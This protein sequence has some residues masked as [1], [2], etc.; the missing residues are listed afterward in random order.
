MKKHIFWLLLPFSLVAGNLHELVELSHQNPMMQAS[1]YSA[2][3]SGLQKD[4]L[5]QSYLPS[6]VLGGSHAYN[7]EKTMSTPE[8]ITTG[9]AKL[10]YT[11]YDGGKRE[12]LE[13]AYEATLKSS[14]FLLHATANDLAL[15]VSYVYYNHFSLQSSLEALEQKKEQLQAELYRLERFL[16]VGSTT[17][18]AL[19]RIQASLEQTKVEVLQTQEAMTKNLNTL[20]YLTAQSIVPTKGSIFRVDEN[21]KSSTERYDILALEQS[22][23][24]AK[25]NAQSAKAPNR[26]TITIEDTY[27]RYGD[28]Y[29][30]ILGT[31]NQNTLS[32][33]VQWK[34][35]DFGSTSSAY[36]ASYKNYLSKSSELAYTKQ[37]AFASLKNAQNSYKTSLAKI[38]SAKLRVKASDA[39]Y[40][41]VKKKFQNGIVDNVAYLDA[42]SEKYSAIA[43]L[44]TAQNDIEYQKAIILYEMGKEIKGAI[45]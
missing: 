41:L 10:S 14:Q 31:D 2:E 40:E 5:T 26:P 22:V 25:A 15:Q 27:S 16:S 33:N 9:Y 7:A 34:I 1:R 44:S 28:D 39:T 35:F 17:Q 23:L 8:K 3:A 43:A 4:A 36:E 6:I 18:D 37:K 13:D 42:L 30:D 19:L 12:A 45:Q 24:S 21:Q 38:E 32:L 20:E 11:L 29:A